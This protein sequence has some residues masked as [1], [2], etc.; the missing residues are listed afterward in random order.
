MWNITVKNGN[1]T[2][3]NA[4]RP[5]DGIVHFNSTM[6]GPSE[7][8]LALTWTG[9][10][11]DGQIVRSLTVLFLL[12]VNSRTS[13]FWDNVIGPALPVQC[14]TIIKEHV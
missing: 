12:H 5:Q 14:S 7:N 13:A 11:A 6:L 10:Q 2:K 9:I 1:I 4:Y 8:E 3:T